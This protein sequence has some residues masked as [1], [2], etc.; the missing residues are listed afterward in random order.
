MADEKDG[1]AE[2]NAALEINPEPPAIGT[3]IVCDNDGRIH[4]F[5]SDEFRF[6]PD[7]GRLVLTNRGRCLAVFCKLQWFKEVKG[8]AEEKVS[9]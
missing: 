1:A 5:Q 7:S 6:D 9:D 3:W 8:D 2:E 4:S